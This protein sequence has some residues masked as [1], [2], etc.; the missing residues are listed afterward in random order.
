MALLTKA[1]PTTYLDEAEV[2]E[3]NVNTGCLC[4]CSLFTQRHPHQH[5]TESDMHSPTL[6]VCSTS[7]EPISKQG[8]GQ[9]QL[10]DPQLDPP[11][12]VYFKHTDGTL[13]P[14][15]TEVFYSQSQRPLWSNAGVNL[16]VYQADVWPVLICVSAAAS[17][18][19]MR[20]PKL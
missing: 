5:R 9:R 2:T 16:T 1:I 6:G 3:G 18:R 17:D 8:Y 10:Q 14:S 13:R 15:T 19:T 4:L 12:K 11:Q 7:S 20:I